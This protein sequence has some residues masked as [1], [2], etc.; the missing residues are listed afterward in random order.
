MGVTTGFSPCFHLPGFPKWVPIFDPQPCVSKCPS[1]QTK[2]IGHSKYSKLAMPSPTVGN[3][4]KHEP[5]VIYAASLV[6]KCQF[7]HLVRS[8][9]GEIADD[10]RGS[11]T[12]GPDIPGVPKT[13]LGSPQ[14]PSKL[15]G[16]CLWVQGDSSTSLRGTWTLGVSVAIFPKGPLLLVILLGCISETSEEK[17]LIS[18]LMHRLSL[19]ARPRR[20]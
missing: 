19:I 8:G 15:S 14:G 10:G 18:L 17:S 13:E 20:K 9:K 1:P 16:S 2:T 11:K 6:G 7:E 3:S 5:D 12:T 4:A